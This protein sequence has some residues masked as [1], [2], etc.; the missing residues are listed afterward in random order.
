[1]ETEGLTATSAA[2]FRSAGQPV[3]ITFELVREQ[4]HGRQIDHISGQSEDVSWCSND[5]VAAMQP[6]KGAN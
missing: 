4:G 1:M 5:L 3:T 2:S 6:A